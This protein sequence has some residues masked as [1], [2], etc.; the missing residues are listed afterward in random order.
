MIDKNLFSKI[1]S[2]E[3]IRL[4]QQL[5]LSAVKKAINILMKAYRM[6][7]MIF[8]T[9]NG[10]SASTA[11]HLAADIGK[12][13]TKSSTGREL[14]RFKIMS[15]T[16]NHSW[17]TA[18][19]ND[20]CYENIFIEQLKNFADKRDV[21]ILISVSGNSQNLIRTALWAKDKGLYTIGLLGLKGGELRNI[22]DTY[23]LI[24][25]ENYGLVESMHSYIQHLFVEELRRRLIQ[26]NEK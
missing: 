7:N 19:G 12:N 3:M 25:S 5:D 4:L 24:P 2:Q 22:V 21:L 6:N 14:K 15:L 23:V 8:V 26:D 10:G 17:I 13:A 9:G 11:E 20:D 18:L 16:V 1:Y